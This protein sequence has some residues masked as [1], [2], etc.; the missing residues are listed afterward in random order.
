MEAVRGSREVDCVQTTVFFV[1]VKVARSLVWRRRDERGWHFYRFFAILQN[2]H[3][4]GGERTD[5][6]TDA[7]KG[8]G[9]SLL[10]SQYI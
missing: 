5:E 4:S 2:T 6:R 7:I 10:A 8:S 1:S 3:L 9:L